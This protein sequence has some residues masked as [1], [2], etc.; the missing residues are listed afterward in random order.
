MPIQYLPNIIS[1]I[2]LCL[3]APFIYY[4]L[5]QKIQTAFLIFVL[6]SCSDALDGWIARVFNCKSRL[7][8]I[9]DPL[10]DKVLIITCFLLLGYKGF[11]DPWLVVLVLLR[12]MAILFGAFLSLFVIKKTQ[13]LYPTIVSKFNTLFQMLLIVLSL[14]DA[15]FSNVPLLI[16]QVTSILVTMTTSISFLQYLYLWK[17]EISNQ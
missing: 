4:F 7:G 2:R 1:F 10:A 14:W 17:K 8:M 16:I 5:S 6:A 3:V 13:P 12:D 11:I 15:S 9:L